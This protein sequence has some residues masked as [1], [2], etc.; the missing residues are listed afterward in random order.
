MLFHRVV[1]TPCFLCYCMSIIL[2]LSTTD[3][4]SFL[5]DDQS[6]VFADL[7][8]VPNST[9]PTSSLQIDQLLELIIG[10]CID[11]IILC[12]LVG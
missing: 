3:A 1:R 8:H 5:V 7:A 6:V 2:M 11:E 12:L 9:S 4:G 10:P